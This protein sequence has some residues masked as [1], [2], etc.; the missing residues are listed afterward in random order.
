MGEDTEAEERVP[1]R[2]FMVMDGINLR[3]NRT[4]HTTPTSTL[5]QSPEPF[6]RPRQTHSPV[7]V[8]PGQNGKYPSQKR[9]RQTQPLTTYHFLD[10]YLQLPIPP[11]VHPPLH[12]HMLIRTLPHSRN[13]GPLQ[14]RVRTPRSTTLSPRPTWDHPPAKGSKGWGRKTNSHA[15]NQTN[16][17]SFVR[18]RTAL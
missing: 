12:L 14:G 9:Q 13:H 10:G 7:I 11:A 5:L 6:L 17:S 16:I 2:R 8:Q 4:A 3:K 1:A 18:P 15:R